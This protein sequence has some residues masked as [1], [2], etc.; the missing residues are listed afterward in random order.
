MLNVVWAQ[1]T[2]REF[3]VFNRAKVFNFSM[4]T[5]LYKVGLGSYGATL[6]E[7]VNMILNYLEFI[8]D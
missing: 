2:L 5:D 6:T 4:V 8:S 3:R 1:G 7:R